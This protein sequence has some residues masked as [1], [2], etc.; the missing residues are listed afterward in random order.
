VVVLDAE[1]KN[2]TYAQTF[3]P[4]F[5]QRFF[6]GFIAE[7]NR[8]GMSVGL[9]AR[10]KI[11]FA[12]SFAC[13]L[14]RACDHIRMAAISQSKLKLYGS[15]AGVGLTMSDGKAFD[16]FLSHNGRDKPAVE[17]LARQLE[18]EAQL[19]PGWTSGISCPVSPSKRHSSR[20]WTI[21]TPARYLLGR[22]ASGHGKMK[23]CAACSKPASARLAFA[24]CQSCC[25]EQ[26]CPSAAPYR[27]FSR[28]SPG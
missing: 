28:S 14:T 27:G 4:E 8:V 19:T 7:Q 2:S 1:V 13:F 9:Q 10:G 23:R 20:L 24:W 12:S 5:P 25:R 21:H 11:P 15:H 16:V 22:V 18:D 26:P 17:V 3:L 6:E